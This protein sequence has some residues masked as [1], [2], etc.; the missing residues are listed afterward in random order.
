MSNRNNLQRHERRDKGKWFVTFIAFLLVFTAVGA[1][2]VGIFSDGFTNWDKFKTD[3]KE[4]VQ[5]DIEGSSGWIVRDDLT[6]ETLTQLN[7]K[8]DWPCNVVTFKDGDGAV[9][10]LYIYLTRD[11]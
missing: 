6:F 1:A 11:V 8:L 5:E 2:F 9:Y 7:G 3:E 10:H 4:Y